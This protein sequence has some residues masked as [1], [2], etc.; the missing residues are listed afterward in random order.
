MHH[1]GRFRWRLPDQRQYDSWSHR[2]ELREV[3][4]YY[5]Y[6]RIVGLPVRVLLQQRGVFIIDVCIVLGTVARLSIRV[7]G[8]SKFR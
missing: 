4:Q 3:H 5:R 1:R 8:L 6:H 2:H 7:P